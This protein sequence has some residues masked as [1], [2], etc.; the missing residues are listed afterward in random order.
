MLCRFVYLLVCRFLDV[1]SGRCRSRLT[2][3]VEMPLSTSECPAT[4]SVS[5]RHFERIPG[6]VALG[7]SSGPPNVGYSISSSDPDADRLLPRTGERLERL[8]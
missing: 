2:K 4:A 3:E 1:L 5:D 7:H 6:V 8:E